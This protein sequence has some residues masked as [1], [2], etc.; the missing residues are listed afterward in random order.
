MILLS[1]VLFRKLRCFIDRSFGKH[2]C[3]IM[4]SKAQIVQI[5]QSQNCLCSV[6]TRQGR[7][8]WCTTFCLNCLTKVVTEPARHGQNVRTCTL[9]LSTYQSCMFETASGP[10]LQV[11]VY[12]T[13]MAIS[14]YLNFRHEPECPPIRSGVEESYPRAHTWPLCSLFLLRLIFSIVPK[15]AD[16]ALGECAPLVARCESNPH[17]RTKSGIPKAIPKMIPKALYPYMKDW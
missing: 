3:A 8:A 1:E 10:P 9:W 6:W 11:H 7:H 2:L 12:F 15:W 17:I 13:H 16:G 4:E 5:E 14:G